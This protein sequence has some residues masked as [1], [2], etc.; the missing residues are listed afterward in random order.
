MPILYKIVSLNFLF[1]FVSL[2]PFS[3]PLS[4]A[5]FCLI[6]A[7]SYLK[8]IC[9]YYFT[10]NGTQDTWT[11]IEHRDQV[12]WRRRWESIWVF[13]LNQWTLYIEHFIQY[14]ARE[15]F[16]H[17]ICCCFCHYYM[18]NLKSS[19][20]GIIFINTVDKTRTPCFYSKIFIGFNL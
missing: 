13:M 11:Q 9:Y 3:L 18:H 16:P 5:N 17:V 12:I 14:L 4:P 2:F 19:H 15:V 10:D 6:F 7:T 8:C 1:L 20:V